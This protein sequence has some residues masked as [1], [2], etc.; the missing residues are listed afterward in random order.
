M[1]IFIFALQFANYSGRSTPKPSATTMLISGYHKAKGDTVVFSARPP[2]NFALYDIVYINKD[3]DG[4]F[5]LQEWLDY[6]N[7]KA[8][9]NFW[10]NETVYYSED[11][12]LTPPDITIYHEWITDFMKKFPS[13]NEKL[14]ET[15][16]QYTPFIMKQKGKIIEP[17]GDK[18]LILDRNWIEW[19]CGFDIV[20]S[21]DIKRLR[22]AYPI[23]IN[24]DYEKVCDLV[25]YCKNIDRNHLWLELYGLI[26]KEKQIEIAKEFKKRKTKNL[27]NLV[28]K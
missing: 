15:F 22:F 27:N 26:P 25:Y 11:W 24:Y 19:D 21:L 17:S 13:K 16:F 12:E 7:V 9:G 23:P 2:K 28:G 10:E 14:F 20:S 5:H 18:I 3:T 6:P 1:K 8:V 4:L